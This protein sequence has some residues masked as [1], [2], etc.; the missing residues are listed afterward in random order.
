MCRGSDGVGQ[1]QN[2]A[3]AILKTQYLRQPRHVACPAAIEN[4]PILTRPATEG[5]T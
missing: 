3:F 1:L 5:S 4:I 2:Q